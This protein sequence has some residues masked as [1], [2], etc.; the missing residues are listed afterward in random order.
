MVCLSEESEPGAAYTLPARIMCILLFNVLVT[1]G[2]FWSL[3]LIKGFLYR[4]ELSFPSLET[5]ITQQNPNSHFLAIIKE[6][7]FSLPGTPVPT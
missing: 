5:R 7:K 1:N 3:T 6:L 4:Q 2:P